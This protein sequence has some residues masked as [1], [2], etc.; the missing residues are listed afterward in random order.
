MFKKVDHV[1]IVPSDFER[2]LNFYTETLGFKVKQRT[3][4][5]RP[6][7]KEIAFIELN[8]SVVEFIDVESPAPVSKEQFQVGYLRI[9]LEVEDMDKAIEY[10]K[11][12]GVQISREPVALGT[13]KRAEILD[14]DGLSIELR[15]WG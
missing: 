1:E 15:Q 6:P 10:L 14:P 11:A 9:A 4:I 8:D 5:E 12:K 7:M 13:S 2:T 3:K